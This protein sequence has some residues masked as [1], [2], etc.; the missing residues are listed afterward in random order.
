MS[1]LVNKNQQDFING[2][3]LGGGASK[4]I[5]IQS[6]TQGDT[7]H[8]PSSDAVYLALQQKS[9]KVLNTFLINDLPTGGDITTTGN[10]DLFEKFEITQ[11][12]ANQVLTLPV[13]STQKT[14]VVA[15]TGTESFEIYGS[16]LEPNQFTTLI[17][18]AVNG[19]I[20]ASGGGLNPSDLQNYLSSQFKGTIDISTNP[21]YPAGVKGDVYSAISTA[22][23]PYNLTG[24]IG[25][26][27]G[28]DLQVGNAIICIKDSLGGDETIAGNDWKIIND[29]PAFEYEDETV[30][31]IGLVTGQDYQ[32]LLYSSSLDIASDIDI[33]TGNPGGNLTTNEVVGGTGTITY[34]NSYLY[35]LQYPRLKAYLNFVN[36]TII[37]P[38]LTENVE[39]SSRINRDTFL[40]QN[41]SESQFPLTVVTQG[42]KIDLN[43]GL[44]TTNPIEIR[45]QS[46]AFVSSIELNANTSSTLRWSHSRQQF[47]E[48]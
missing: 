42:F 20:V 39:L 35:Q 16:K 27:N 9:D 43:T 7:T 32:K 24:K 25:G 44:P 15:N 31:G 34:T 22:S 17:Y 10:I 37:M 28:K 23:A 4:K 19:W 13:A 41:D 18:N 21:N 26:A 45:T 14:V 48:Q 40:I 29:L 30:G 36:G 46:G 6:V 33:T 8:A 11:T 1:F 3:A 47:E 38:Y 5:L 2:V 12:T